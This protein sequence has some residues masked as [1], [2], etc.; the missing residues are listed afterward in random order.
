MLKHGKLVA[1]AL[2]ALTLGGMIMATGCGGGGPEGAAIA[3]MQ[4]IEAMEIGDLTDLTASPH[5][6]AVANAAHE[7]KSETYE[8][9]MRLTYFGGK[10]HHGYGFTVSNVDWLQGATE[11]EVHVTYY[12]GKE[13]E[14][15]EEDRVYWQASV[16]LTLI[17]GSWRV[18]GCVA[19]CVAPGEDNKVKHLRDAQIAEMERR[20]DAAD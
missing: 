16:A 19:H 10:D 14:S 5:A 7:K 4:A 17:N 18:S 3:Y 2:V 8:K 6:A 1:F 11:A 20:V 15:E 9:A 12:A 13:D